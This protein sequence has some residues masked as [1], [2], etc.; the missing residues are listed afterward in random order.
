[1]S[2]SVHP[3]GKLALTVGTDKTLRWKSARV[4]KILRPSRIFKQSSEFT[5]SFSEHGIC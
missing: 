3:S 5:F 2:L 4:K 1:M